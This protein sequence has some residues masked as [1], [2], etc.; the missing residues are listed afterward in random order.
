MKHRPKFW[1][2]QPVFFND[3]SG[4]NSGEYFVDEILSTTTDN[5]LNLF[6]LYRLWGNG[7]S[8][9]ANEMEMERL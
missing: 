8:I 5:L 4:L 2:G 9:V 3:Y 6:Q 7:K 1:L